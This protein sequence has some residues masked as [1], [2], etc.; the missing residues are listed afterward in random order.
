MSSQ[1]E[2]PQK[3]FGREFKL[4]VNKI[5][6]GVSVPLIGNQPLFDINGIIRACVYEENK[7]VDEGKDSWKTPEE[8]QEFRDKIDRIINLLAEENGKTCIKGE[9]LKSNEDGSYELTSECPCFLIPCPN[10]RD[11]SLPFHVLEANNGY[12]KKCED[13]EG[14]DK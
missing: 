13:G 12:C 2:K 4:T 5:C 11:V 3:G 10:C 6:Q 7:A 1:E 14:E 9:C 8:W